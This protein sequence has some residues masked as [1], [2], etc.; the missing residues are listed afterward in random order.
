M[1]LGGNE[2]IE[3]KSTPTDR[4]FIW[5]K[6]VMAARKRQLS[7]EGRAL[8][9]EAMRGVGPRNLVPLEP[10]PG[11]TVVNFS[12]SWAIDN[13]RSTSNEA[14]LIALGVGWLKRKAANAVTPS[15]VIVH[16]PYDSPPTWKATLSVMG[17]TVDGA[18]HPYPQPRPEP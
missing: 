10:Q 4:R 8:L 1:P 13:S 16:K 14:T 7:N 17:M 15:C 11:E 18:P 3:L 12:G 5:T 9:N 6:R 2:T